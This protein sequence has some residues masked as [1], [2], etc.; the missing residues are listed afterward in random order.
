MSAELTDY[1]VYIKDLG[2]PTIALIYLF[3]A[4]QNRIEVGDDR[5]LRYAKILEDHARECGA[6]V[7]TLK[8]LSIEIKREMDI[9]QEFLSKLLDSTMIHN[10][11]D[12]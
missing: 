12:L 7:E 8:S 3:R 10:R 11:R 9:R 1:F 4:Y 2:L 5:E 6:L